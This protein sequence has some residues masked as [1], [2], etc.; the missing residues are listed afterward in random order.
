[1]HNIELA[2]Q[3]L[4]IQLMDS[5]GHYRTFSDIIEELRDVW[6]K[7]SEREQGYIAQNITENN[8]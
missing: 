1:M 3:A 5:N 7:L 2:F 8:E 4:G 6:S